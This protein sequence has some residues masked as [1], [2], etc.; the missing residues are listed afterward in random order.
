MDD[1]APPTTTQKIR[2]EKLGIQVP[3]G[4]TKAQLRALITRTERPTPDQLQL[5]DG[6]GI[7]FSK[8]TPKEALQRKI[9]VEMRQRSRRSA[10]PDLAVR[11]NSV[12]VYEGAAYRI[13]ALQKFGGCWSAN[14]IPCD[15]GR[16]RQVPILSILNAKSAN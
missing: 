10:D 12:I 8:E 9:D 6:L 11:V 7:A 1:D 13:S 2:A 4:M 3:P 16:G 14:I 15:G 5:A